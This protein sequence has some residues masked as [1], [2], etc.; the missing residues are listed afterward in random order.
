VKRF[1]LN[2]RTVALLATLVALAVP[3]AAAATLWVGNGE[4]ESGF[5]VKSGKIVP[6]KGKKY[7]FAPSN[8]KCNSANLAVK[9]T[10][11]PVTGGKIDFVG[12]AHIDW[13]RFPKAYGKLTW[14]G[15]LKKGVI[16][17]ETSKTPRYKATG[18]YLVNK[19]CDTGKL[20]YTVRPA[21]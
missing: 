7:I 18:P 1:G 19:A 2:R 3:A 16:R 4:G 15:T 11:I 6:L 8:F 12:K 9:T 13:F 10:S 21:P 17:F 14:K 5:R 20:H